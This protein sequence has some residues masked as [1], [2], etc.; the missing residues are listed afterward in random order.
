MGDIN[1]PWEYSWI[2]DAAYARLDECRKTNPSL[3]F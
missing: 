3:V 1:E 2:D